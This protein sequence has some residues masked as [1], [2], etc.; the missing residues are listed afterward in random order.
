MNY[1]SLGPFLKISKVQLKPQNRF[2]FTQNHRDHHRS[3]PVP[4]VFK[5]RTE[6][7][8]E[9][10]RPIGF[11][12]WPARPRIDDRNVKVWKDYARHLVQNAPRRG[13]VF[14]PHENRRMA[15][16]AV[17]FF[18][19]GKELFF[20]KN[21]KLMS[22][23]GWLMFLLFVS[24]VDVDVGCCCWCCRLLVAF[25]TPSQSMIFWTFKKQ[26]PFLRHDTFLTPNFV[27]DDSLIL[28]APRFRLL[29]IEEVRVSRRFNK[30][31]WWKHIRKP[32]LR[33][34]NLLLVTKC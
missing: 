33:N 15:E 26:L 2:V 19:G 21:G 18:W 22:G 34:K 10:P 11:R 28:P 29:D 30:N 23:G 6:P 8:G 3:A 9:A 7:A 24:V 14:S 1:W 13:K 12:T 31:L 5:P 27:G 32:F 4:T 16:N 20:F 17:I 25:G